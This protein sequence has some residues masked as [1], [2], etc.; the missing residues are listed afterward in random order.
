MSVVLLGEEPKG[1]LPNISPDEKNED[2]DESLK[3]GASPDL[4]AATGAGFSFFQKRIKVDL[5]AIA[6]QRSVF[7][8]PKTLDVYRPPPQYENA[9]RFD[10]QARWSWREEKASPFFE[11]PPRSHSRTGALFTFYQNVVRKIDFRIMIWAFVM[12]FALDLDRGNLSQANAD[13]FLNDL[14]LNTNDFNLGNT[15]FSVSFL[16]SG[17]F[18]RFICRVSTHMISLFI[19]LPSQ[20]VSK[21]VGPDVWIPCQVTNYPTIYKLIKR[22][23]FR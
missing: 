9:H 15:L 7:D 2:N 1:A 23:L 16:C 12:F 22:T 21:R 19:E 4:A 18:V 10:P 5:D 11:F 14:G 17:D 6:T 3:L 20:L 8:D 13:N